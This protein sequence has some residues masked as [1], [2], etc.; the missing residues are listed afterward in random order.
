MVCE[1]KRKFKI[2]M[3]KTESQD[4]NYSEVT[5]DMMTGSMKRIVT[6]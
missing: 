5:M 4:L 6:L 1:I 2:V 3:R